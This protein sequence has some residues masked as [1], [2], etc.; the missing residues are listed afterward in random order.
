MY[1]ITTQQII[2]AVPEAHIIQ[3]PEDWFLSLPPDQSVFSIFYRWLCQ[4]VAL[5]EAATVHI[6]TFI[7]KTLFKKLVQ[8]ERARL[9]EFNGYRG[10][11]LDEHVAWVLL[12]Y[13]AATSLGNCY[14][15]DDS[16]LVIPASSLERLQNLTEG[17]F[18]QKRRQHVSRIK[19]AAKGHNFYTW[20]LAQTK[21]PD[22]IG[23]LACYIE[24]DV[25]WPVD[26]DNLEQL[27]SYLRIQTPKGLFDRELS[28][29]WSEYQQQVPKQLSKHCSKAPASNYW[30]PV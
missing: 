5:T 2:K 22:G 9:R 29:A 13:S 1:S 3:L 20:M 6:T 7:G 30:Q 25:F 14:F 4:T 28:A 27:K 19:D 12:E 8:A 17:I 10:D 26:L 15:R 21:R 23:N 16:I 18:L 24:L 11:H